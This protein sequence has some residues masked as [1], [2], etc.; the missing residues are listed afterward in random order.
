MRIFL[1]F[2]FLIFLPL[3]SLFS[4]ESG[5]VITP[6]TKYNQ[7]RF[8]FETGGGYLNRPGDGPIYGGGSRLTY[9]REYPMLGLSAA[10]MKKNWELQLYG[11]STFGY[12]RSGNFR[13]EDFYLFSPDFYY[14]G[15][16]HNIGPFYGFE[17]NNSSHLTRFSTTSNWSDFDSSLKAKDSIAGFDFRY[18]PAGGSPNPKTKGFGLFLLGGYSYEYLKFI[19]TDASGT[20]LDYNTGRIYVS[21]L[22]G[23]NITYSNSIHEIK[24]GL[25]TQTNFQRWGFEASFSFVTSE[26][27]SRDFHKNRALTFMEFAKGKGW[28]HSIK[29]NYILTD[30]LV[31]NF[32]WTESFKEF[33]GESHVKAG[34][35][36]ESWRAA[37]V[38]FNQPYWLYSVQNQVSLGLSILL[39]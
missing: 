39:F 9:S 23:E 12:R 37:F 31:L 14:A 5:W 19:V 1:K 3:C 28:I 7:G 33:D 24:Y 11:N 35:G 36:P 13:D 32:N 30:N 16:F 4:E 29:I 38:S 20:Q 21:A 27:R 2:L 6:S 34:L 25:G 26:I 18:F 17:L 10:Y 8:I 15:R 22:N